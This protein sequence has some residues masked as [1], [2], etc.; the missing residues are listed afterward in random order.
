MYASAGGS[1]V[2][3]ATAWG[4]E[5]IACLFANSPDGHAACAHIPGEHIPKEAW[6]EMTEIM[7]ACPGIF[8]FI[9]LGTNIN[10]WKRVIGYLRGRRSTEDSARPTKSSAATDEGSTASL[11]EDET[12]VPKEE[13]NNAG[14]TPAEK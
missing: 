4:N 3:G 10:D 8:Y 14:E 9:T 11:V 7:A 13:D 5:W 12:M 6:T 2:S 1:L